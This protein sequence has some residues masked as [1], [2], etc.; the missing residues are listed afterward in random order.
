M[1]MLRNLFCDWHHT[2]KNFFPYGFLF[3]L[4]ILFLQENRKEGALKFSYYLTSSFSL[5][6]HLQPGYP[7][8]KY[9]LNKI[10]VILFLCGFLIINRMNQTI[11]LPY[12]LKSFHMLRPVRHV[13]NT[14]LWESFLCYFLFYLLNDA[15]EY[16]L[17]R[18]NAVG[19]IRGK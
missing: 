14:I 1:E 5:L 12:V 7:E 15:L 8:T 3:P 13:L 17:T 16:V 6:E 18:N 9:I 10:P 2:S 11:K 4:F 19:Q